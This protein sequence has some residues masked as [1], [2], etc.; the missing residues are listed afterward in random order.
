LILPLFILKFIQNFFFKFPDFQIFHT[1]KNKVGH[2]VYT[3]V[4]YEVYTLSGY[5]CVC[6]Y[7]YNGAESCNPFS[8]YKILQI[9]II[10]AKC[11]PA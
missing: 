11:R 10:D 3:C 8:G 7:I 6:I 1:V 4:T 2:F 9:R 5:S